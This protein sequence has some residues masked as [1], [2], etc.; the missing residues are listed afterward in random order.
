MSFIQTR[1]YENSNAASD[2]CIKYILQKD[3]IVWTH[4]FRNENIRLNEHFLLTLEEFKLVPNNYKSAYKKIEINDIAVMNCLVEEKV[5]SVDGT[6]QV[7][8]DT[9]NE[10][11]ALAGNWKVYFEKDDEFGYWYIYEVQI[12]GIN[13]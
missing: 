6:Y 13:F 2:E 1:F 8:A 3:P 4:H 11:I 7:T 9:G 5:C 10:K 12:E